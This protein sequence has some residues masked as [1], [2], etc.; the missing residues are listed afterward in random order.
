MLL[1]GRWSERFGPPRAPVGGLRLFGAG[2]LV[3]GLA[4]HMPVRVA[5]RV[6]QGLGGGMLGVTLYVGMGQVA[7]PAPNPRLFCLLAAAW[8][9]PGPVGLAPAATLVDPV[10][11]R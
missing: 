3:A 2:L 9:V 8:V 11:W 10:G 1:A 4:A 5:G 7:P 6:L